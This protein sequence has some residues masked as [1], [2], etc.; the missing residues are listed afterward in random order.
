MPTSEPWIVDHGLKECLQDSE[1]DFE[2]QDELRV[3]SI[4]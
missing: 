3:L 2:R 1:F 4:G